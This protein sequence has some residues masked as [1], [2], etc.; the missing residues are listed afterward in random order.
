[1]MGA[2]SQQHHQIKQALK[3]SNTGI[4]SVYNRSRHKKAGILN[5]AKLDDR[6]HRANV[7]YKS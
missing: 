6:H 7:V 5:S 4:K 2:L 3:K 1:M